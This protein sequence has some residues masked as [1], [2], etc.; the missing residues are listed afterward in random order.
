MKLSCCVGTSLEK[1]DSLKNVGYKYCE[2]ALSALAKLSD[3]D[4]AAL[5]AKLSETGITPVSANGMFPGEINLLLG[6]AGYP[7]VIEY[8]DKAFPRAKE[9]GIPVIILGSGGSRKIPEDMTKEEAENRFCALLTDV[10]SPKCTE[11][12]LIIGIEE[13]NA[14]ECNFINSCKEAME[15]IRRVNLPNI[16]L[17]VDFYH[18]V[19][20]GDTMTELESYGT[21][22]IVHAHYGSPIN[23]RKAPKKGVDEH[24]IKEYFDM[25][26]RIGYEG[27]F[28]LEGRFQ[29]FDADIAE[30]FEI[31]N[32]LN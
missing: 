32:A 24:L 27:A 7:A 3:E 14:N 16:K 31:M 23:E 28:S 11:Y 26:K 9:L 8:L 15:L 22:Y 18:A 4:Y 6:E 30:A 12:G 13:L 25:F 10:I 17:L 1:L 19:L 29:D 21:E 20:G 2:V 5:K